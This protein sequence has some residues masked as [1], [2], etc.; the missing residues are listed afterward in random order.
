MIS[1][2][3]NKIKMLALIFS[4]VWLAMIGY[5]L[6]KNPNLPEISHS[7]ARQARCE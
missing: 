6:G 1:L 3:Y 7:S 4:L 2:S 5:A